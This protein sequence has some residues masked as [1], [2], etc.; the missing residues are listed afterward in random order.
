MKNKLCKYF[1]GTREEFVD[2]LN[3]NPGVI[4]DKMICFIHPKNEGEDKGEG[5]IYTR[6]VFFEMKKTNI[7]VEVNFEVES[8][9]DYVIVKKSQR[10]EG[11][12]TIEVRTITFNKSQ[13]LNGDI[14]EAEEDDEKL[15][16]NG[17]LKKVMKLNKT[18]EI[19]NK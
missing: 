16:T 15:V 1:I 14:T 9:D 3:N 12:K 13:I 6:G 10:E 4:N 7:E 8:G 5:W 19:L 11:G 18:I 2:W 17:Y